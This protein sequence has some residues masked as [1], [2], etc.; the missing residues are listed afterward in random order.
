MYAG[1]RR[2]ASRASAV[3]RVGRLFS[4]SGLFSSPL[5]H[6]L[7]VSKNDEEFRHEHGNSGK[8]V[9]KIVREKEKTETHHHGSL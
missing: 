7:G 8:N 3:V 5:I 2:R 4:A 9:T 6:V 1:R